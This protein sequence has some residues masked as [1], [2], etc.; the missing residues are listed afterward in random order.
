MS[1]GGA[2]PTLRSGL[3]LPLDQPRADRDYLRLMRVMIAEMFQLRW[4]ILDQQEVAE[5]IHRAEHLHGRTF[6]HDMMVSSLAVGADVGAFFG[7]DLRRLGRDGDDR[8]Q[9]HVTLRDRLAGTVEFKLHHFSPSGTNN[10]VAQNICGD[11]AVQ[12]TLCL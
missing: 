2:L 8:D 3:P 9:V 10:T 1:V 5:S 6:H 4:L 12:D 11:V 7:I